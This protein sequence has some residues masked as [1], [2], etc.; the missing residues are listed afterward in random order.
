MRGVHSRGG[1]YFGGTGHTAN[2]T[3]IK[4]S[5]VVAICDVDESLFPIESAQI[6]KLGGDKPKTVVDFRKLLD[7]KD[8]DAVSIATT[9]LL[10][11]T[12]Y[13]LGM[14]GREGCIC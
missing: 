8:I 12:S 11:R 13:D 7:D 6:V 9:G 3:K 2:Y 4:D 10:A 5:R 1:Y 14:P